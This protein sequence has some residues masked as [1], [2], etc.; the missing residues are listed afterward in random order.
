MSAFFFPLFFFLFFSPSL[1]YFFSFSFP[2][3]SPLR[4]A[5][6]SWVPRAV[7]GRAVGT[8]HPPPGRFVAEGGLGAILGWELGTELLWVKD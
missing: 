3:P 1:F 8:R 7:S 5:A 6:R 2:F 4:L